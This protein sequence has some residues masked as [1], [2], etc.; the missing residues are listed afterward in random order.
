MSPRKGKHGYMQQRTPSYLLTAKLRNNIRR[1]HKSARH[2]HMGRGWHWH[3]LMKHLGGIS[4][5]CHV[6]V[7][8]CLMLHREELE[9][10]NK[11]ASITGL[12]I[13]RLYYNLEAKQ[14]QTDLS[15]KEN[16]RIELKPQEN[17]FCFKDLAVTTNF[18]WRFVP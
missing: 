11:K 12:N 16:E 10:E 18:P 3:G 2:V 9:N 17:R 13:L 1:W 6:H 14:P 15:A 4:R 8:R 7:R 5:H